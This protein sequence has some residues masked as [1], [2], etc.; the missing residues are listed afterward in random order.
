MTYIYEAW[1]MLKGGLGFCKVLLESLSRNLF[2]ATVPTS[3]P[4]KDVHSGILERNENSAR[5]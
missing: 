2:G 1:L 5:F 3:G 4:A